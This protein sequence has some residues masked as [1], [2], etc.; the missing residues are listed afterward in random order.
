MAWNHVQKGTDHN[1]F[2][3]SYMDEAFNELIYQWDTSFMT[4]FAVYAR[5]S[6][7][8]MQSLD[9]FYRKQR[10]DGYIQR[11][12]WES[13]GTMASNPTPE[14]PMVNP[15]LFA[16]ME[17]R[18]V[19]LS[20]DTSRVSRIY[21]VLKTY[22]HWLE[23]N[24][25]HPDGRGLYYQTDL[26]SGMDNIPRPGVH[27]GGWID[28]SAQMVL[29]AR[30]MKHLAGMAGQ[31]NDRVE[32]IQKATRDSALIQ[33]FCWNEKT[34][35]YHDLRP[36]GSQSPVVHIGAVWA[37]LAGIPT[38]VQIGRMAAMLNDPSTFNRPHRVPSLAANDPDYDPLGHYWRGGV[39]APT[40]FATVKGLQANGEHEL[41]HDIA[42]NHLTALSKIYASPGI[43]D[44]AITW[45]DRFKDGYHTLWECYAPDSLQ[46]GTRWDQTFRGRQDFVGWTGLGPIALLIETVLGIAVDSRNGVIE[47]E[48]SGQGRQ[49]IEN[50]PFRQSTVS[51]IAEPGEDSCK[52]VI[53]CKDP[54]LLNMKIGNKV[55]SVPVSPGQ[56]EQFLPVTNQ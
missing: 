26:G 11:V 8:A 47:W 13:D 4:A 16:W 32:W 25:R 44:S 15:P 14:E 18:Y 10:E 38:P 20:G 1:G 39:W 35:W 43:S 55:F 28:Q 45:E 31:P 5:P 52:V 24:L 29:F 51:L 12:Y 41:A 37:M 36:D 54:F 2:T 17:W 27:F 40:T 21:P 53:E 42:V 9:N 34:G 49:G 19:L 50:L 6:F 22:F 7:P 3:G 46:P 30:M 56:S 33:T 48:F 23:G